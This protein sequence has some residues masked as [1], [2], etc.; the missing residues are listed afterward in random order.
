VPTKAVNVNL[1]KHLQ[2]LFTLL[3]GGPPHNRV[4]PGPG[5]ARDPGISCAT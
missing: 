1:R 2:R 4:M 5:E 3:T